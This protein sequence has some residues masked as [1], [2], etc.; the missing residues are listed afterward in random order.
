MIYVEKVTEC[1]INIIKFRRW[2]DK[3]LNICFFMLWMGI[4]F[5][6]FLKGLPT[7]MV[8]SKS[9]CFITNLY[10]DPIVKYGPGPN[11]PGSNYPKAM[12]QALLAG[13]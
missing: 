11:I 2:F 9:F 12:Q 1:P 4:F 13:R 8:Y 7:T 3:M 5:F 10:T 6:F